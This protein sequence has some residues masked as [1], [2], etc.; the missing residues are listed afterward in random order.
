M[1]RMVGI[2]L[3]FQHQTGYPHPHRDVV[4][5]NYRIL[6]DEMGYSP[7]DIQRRLADVDADARREEP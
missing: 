4:V 6:L 5:N 3:R 1:Q 7:H 2:I